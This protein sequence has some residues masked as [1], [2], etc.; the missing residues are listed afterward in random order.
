MG[1]RAIA[2]GL[3]GLAQLVERIVVRYCGESCLDEH[4]AFG[5]YVA[6]LRNYY[7]QGH[8]TIESLDVEFSKLY[9][10]LDYPEWLTMLSR[11]CEYATDIPA[12]EEPF[13][14]E[15]AYIAG[16]WEAA[17][18]RADFESKY[19]REVSNQHDAKYD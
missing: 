18:S 12:F 3:R 5:K 10:R 9:S 13:E 14:K 15:F 11:N 1:T 8:E 7:L 4:L 19:S 6:S 16:L 2:A 17:K